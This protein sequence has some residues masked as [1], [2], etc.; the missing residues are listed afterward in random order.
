MKKSHF[1]LFVALFVTLFFSAQKVVS[2]YSIP[3]KMNWW[4]E[5]RFGMF[6]HFGS[7][8][9]LAKGE[10][11]MPNG[12]TKSTY[13]TNVSA[14]FNPTNFNAGTIARLAQKAGMKY[15][16]IT[17]KHHEGFCMWDTQVASFKDVTGKKD[18]DLP[19]FTAF[20]KRDILKELKDSCDA[21]G[22]KFCLYYSILDWNH[23]SQTGFYSTTMKSFEARTAYIA[24]MKAQLKELI[25][26]YHPAIMWF[27]G[28]W[29]Y[30]WGAATLA[31]WWTKADG[32]D[33]YNYLTE[34][35]P[36]L[37]VNERVFRGAG[38]GDWTCPEGV[39][40]AAPES[41]PWETCQTMNDTWGY[42]SGDNNY[43][44]PKAL[45][46]QLVQVVSRD[47]NYLLNIG[48]KG[49]GSV[50]EQSIADLN[51]IGDWMKIY[52]SSIYGATRSP[53]ALEPTWGLYT[54]KAGKLYTHVFSWPANGL[55]KVPSLTNTINKI[56]LLN[57]TTTLLS[58]KDSIGYIRISVPVKVPNANNSV[59]VIDVNGVPTASTEY[60]KVSSINVMGQDGLTSIQDVGG[61]LQMSAVVTPTTATDSTVTWSVSDAT[62]ASISNTGLLIAN[63]DGL[64]TV[65]ATAKDDSDS[66]GQ[67]QIT[68][69]T[70]QPGVNL[71]QNS[72][73]E[74]QGSWMVTQCDVNGA[75][76]AAFGTDGTGP[77]GG[78]NKFLE[79]KCPAAG[80]SS[81]VFVY[82]KVVVKRGRAY[83]FSAAMKDVSTTLVDGW[84]GIAWTDQKPVTGQ[85]ISEA[86][87][88]NFDSKQACNGK[89][90]DGLVETSCAASSQY[91]KIPTSL[92]SDTIY[93]GINVGTYGATGN[94]DLYF[95]NVTLTD[96]IGSVSAILGSKSPLQ[97]ACSNPANK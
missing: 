52:S 6:I 74:T 14:K 94:I 42:N 65:T 23:S 70:G 55:L 41:R 15:L 64:V 89:G 53:F 60:T 22:V 57:D 95:D 20:K 97:K 37:L 10:W 47:G 81:Q 44:T 18:Y 31:S 75:I 28:D 48:P 3:A 13:Q 50:T 67:A 79:L 4:Y 93:F 24:D 30:N 1:Y 61:A 40:P 88:A 32:E 56:Y 72:D 27:D 76:N 77:Q 68:V 11:D 91:F 80:S 66:F 82:Q 84:I 12:W 46:Q 19:G 43:K 62:I 34:L 90:F 39:V 8:S 2:Q 78:A 86:N 51:A 35:D 5:S 83:K 33:L 49:D 26:K 96:S 17:A 63:K 69:G 36:N 58:Y 59:V 92:S 45:I 9:Y 7:Y 73:C 85:D 87:V 25:D 16:V 54:K 71:L 38:L 29:T 21:V